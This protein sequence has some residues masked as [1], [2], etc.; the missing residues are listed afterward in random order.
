VR[1]AAPARRGRPLRP[2]SRKRR[3]QDRPYKQAVALVFQRAAGRCEVVLEGRRCRAIAVDPHHV[4]KR[5]AG[6]PLSD[7]SNLVAVCR[8]CHDRTDFDYATGRLVVTPLGAERFDFRIVTAA[9]KF[10][11]REAQ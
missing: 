11:A 8:A 1:R 3:R 5:S 2:V 7:P 10:A 4:V 6:G 9:N